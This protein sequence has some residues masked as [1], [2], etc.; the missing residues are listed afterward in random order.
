M[1]PTVIL[2]CGVCL[3]TAGCGSRSAGSSTATRGRDTVVDATTTT[4]PNP[5][6]PSNSLTIPPANPGALRRIKPPSASMLARARHLEPAVEVV[7]DMPA[8]IPTGG[9]LIADSE[10]L[11]PNSGPAAIDA[12]RAIGAGTGGGTP[13]QELFATLDEP[14]GPVNG[15]AVWVV[16][17][18]LPP[19]DQ[20]PPCYG[21]PGSNCSSG[22]PYRFLNT[23]VLADGDGSNGAAGAIITAFYTP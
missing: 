9:I 17:S 16:T 19:G 6:H 10:L 23:I 2:M 15:A 11:T 18:L 5:T 21:G 14:D 8:T 12:Q 7:V 4:Q 13:V 3:V 20:D 22:G 1:R